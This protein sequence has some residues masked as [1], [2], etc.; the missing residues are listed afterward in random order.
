[1]KVGHICIAKKLR[2]VTTPEIPGE[3]KSNQQKGLKFRQKSMEIVLQQ[4]PMRRNLVRAKFVR[5]TLH[6][7]PREKSYTRSWHG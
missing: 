2:I 1:M 6:D 3:I 5:G 7:I 4:F